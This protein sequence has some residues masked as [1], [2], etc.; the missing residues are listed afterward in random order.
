[1]DAPI[2]ETS[3]EQLHFDVAATPGHLE[4]E[5]GLPQSVALQAACLQTILQ[6]DETE[7]FHSQVKKRRPLSY[8]ADLYSKKDSERAMMSLSQRTEINLEGSGYVVDHR[9]ESLAWEVQSHYLDLQICVGDGLGLA[10]MLPNVGTH[11]ALEF[12][13]ELRYRTRRFQAKY[14][15]LGFDPTN[16]MLWIGRSSSGEDTWLAWVPNRHDDD[17][18]EGTVT[19]TGKE[20]TIL[21]EKQYRLT[22]MFLAEMLRRIGH[23]DIIVTNRYPNLADDLEYKYATNLM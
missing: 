20:D 11:H 9:E 4:T 2:I 8:F 17:D 1:M 7:R 10:A 21:P 18:N 12:R 15:K 3:S 19:G 22:V 6:Q 23:R 13:M 16:S 5:D 14:A